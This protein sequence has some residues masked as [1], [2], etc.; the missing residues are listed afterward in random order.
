MDFVFS[1]AFASNSFG[2]I[3]TSLPGFAAGAL[4]LTMTPFLR[5]LLLLAMAGCLGEAADRL[6]IPGANTLVANDTDRHSRAFGLALINTSWAVTSTLFSS[7]LGMITDRRG[8]S[9]TFLM[10]VPLA[11]VYAILHILGSVVQSER[12]RFQAPLNK[13]LGAV[14]STSRDFMALPTYRALQRQATLSICGLGAPDS[15]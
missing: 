1:I 14:I 4:A 3:T 7:I 15:R 11:V 2:V 8:L 13:S 6:R 10:A 5:M 9:A 12:P